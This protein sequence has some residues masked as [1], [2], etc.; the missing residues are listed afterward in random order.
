MENFS[1]KFSHEISP[2]HTSLDLRSEESFDLSNMV[3]EVVKYNKISDKDGY[4]LVS[5]GLI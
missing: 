5:S 3:I 2:I 1:N 4:H